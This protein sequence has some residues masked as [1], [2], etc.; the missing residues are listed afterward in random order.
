[1][2]IRMKISYEACLQHRTLKE[3]L[4]LAILKAYHQRKKKGLVEYP[5]P[6]LTKKMIDG[7][8]KSCLRSF[9]QKSMQQEA[10][11]RERERLRELGRQ[12][13]KSPHELDQD[14]AKRGD[15]NPNLM[16]KVLTASILSKDG[17]DDLFEK[18]YESEDEVDDKGL[19]EM[20]AKEV[21]SD[22]CHV[23]DDYHIDKPGDDK[24]KN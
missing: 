3:L 20:Y 21:E 7:I 11:D 2:K 9:T 13:S 23:D 19:V 8:R 22:D 1:M 4:L 16:F 10:Q 12:G 15:T 24:G 6:D 17:I 18:Y 5:Y 14:P